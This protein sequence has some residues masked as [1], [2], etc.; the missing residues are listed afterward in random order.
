MLRPA[1][2]Q[3]IRKN[4]SYYTFVVEVAKRAREIAIEADDNHTPLD[5]KPVKLAVEAFARERGLNPEH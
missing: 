3:L 2:S 4:E 5:E 1:M